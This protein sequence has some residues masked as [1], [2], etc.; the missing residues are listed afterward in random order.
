MKSALSEKKGWHRSFERLRIQ[1]LTLL[2]S[3][4]DKPAAAMERD[5]SKTLHELRVY[6][7]ELELQNEELRTT[8]KE[9]EIAH[10]RYFELFNRAP[11]GYVIMDHRGM[12]RQ[13]N[14]TLA[15][16][17]GTNAGDMRDK[18]FS[19]FIDQKK[20]HIF[21]STLP[22]I[23]KAK[24][25][26][27]ME[28]LLLGRQKR[29]LPVLAEMETM[30][31]SLIESGDTQRPVILMTISDITEIKAAQDS[32]MHAKQEW[33]KTFD[34]VTELVAIIDDN[35]QVKRVNRALA[36]RLKRSPKECIGQPCYKL[37][38][39]LEA[40]PA[41]CPYDRMIATGEVQR[42]ERYEKHLGGHYLMSI[43]PFE[44]VSPDGSWYIHV[45]ADISELKAIEAERLENERKIR[46]LQK[47]EAIGTLAGGV[48]HDF[49]NI[50]SI[51]LGNIELSL[52]QLPQDH[53]AWF[54][55]HE[56]HTA[57]L[58]AQNVVRQ[59][60]S[61]ARENHHQKKPTLV[62]KVVSE[63]VQLMRASLPT[64]IE[65]RLDITPQNLVVLADSTQLQQ[66][67]INLCTNAAHAMEEGGGILLVQLEKRV[68]I[69]PDDRL[70]SL[71]PGEYAQLTVLDSGHGIKAE[72]IDRIF[73]PYFTTKEVGKGTGMGLAVVHGIVEDH[74]GSIH[75]RSQWGQNT[76]FSV[77]LPLTD[78]EV[79][80]AINSA[81]SIP[82]GKERVL[83]VD[84]E[85]SLA[86]L[87]QVM[88]IKLGYDA[89]YV[90]D[91]YLALDLLKTDS[92]WD[93]VL[94]DL[95]MPRMSGDELI[96]KIHHLNPKVATL[97]YSGFNEKIARDTAARIG[98]TGYL[99]KPVN[100]KRLAQAIRAALDGN[101]AYG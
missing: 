19:A 99:E 9:L 56:V 52:D 26:K 101:S 79:D 42:V 58:R 74:G 66:V 87:V 90:T 60:L 75:V 21:F 10:K 2:D 71:N 50:L 92:E 3:Q 29:W 45:S 48:A 67:L 78:Q 93:L 31:S 7:T 4:P 49:N 17:L 57:S 11:V 30:P 39:N 63:A 77:Y 84:D 68:L 22:L 13:T 95:T 82:R 85:L 73:D 72:H 55:L 5:I 98:A 6:Q 40:P 91:P 25:P 37:I 12:V 100:L 23:A 69:E 24:R 20:Q 59:L 27:K 70:P 46:R 32:I 86:R 96:R 83:V 65:I 97:L 1:A 16:M 8:Q 35:H 64:S 54:N 36:Q 47:I 81:S 34:S 44:A 80:A 89:T 38:H 94:S 76:Q 62:G 43:S 15:E 41:E 88:L 18:P 28:L 51:I 33:E 14:N 61:F 53:P